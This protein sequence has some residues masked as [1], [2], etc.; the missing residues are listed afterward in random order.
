[1]YCICVKYKWIIEK[2]ESLNSSVF[3]VGLSFLKIFFKKLIIFYI[4]YYFNVL[5][6]KIFLKK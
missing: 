1:M 3:R 4:F 5:I 6:L 2:K